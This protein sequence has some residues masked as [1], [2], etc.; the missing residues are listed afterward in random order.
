MV[1]YRVHYAWK[2]TQKNSWGQISQQ[3]NRKYRCFHCETHFTRFII[4]FQK[5]RMADV[6]VSYVRELFIEQEPLKQCRKFVY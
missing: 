6:S 2:K 1:E 5:H 3:P 4:N